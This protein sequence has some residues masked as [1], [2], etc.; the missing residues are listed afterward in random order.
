MCLFCEW[1]CSFQISTTLAF[2]LDVSFYCDTNAQYMLD[3]LQIPWPRTFKR[4]LSVFDFVNFDAFDFT[5]SACVA[6]VSFYT[7]YTVVMLMP[8]TLIAA[9]T[10]CYLLPMLLVT[11]DPNAKW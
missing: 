4:F 1:D 7:N 11:R 10:L 5:Q 3:F 9:L 2:N 6:N 8:L